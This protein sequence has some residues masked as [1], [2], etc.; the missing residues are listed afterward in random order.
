VRSFIHLGFCGPSL[1]KMPL[2]VDLPRPSEV[3]SSGHDKGTRQETRI[4]HC[5]STAFPR[6]SNRLDGGSW[7]SLKPSG[8]LSEWKFEV[9]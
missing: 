6:P 9:P 5:C 1:M 2:A 8:M 3:K 7:Q 4:G